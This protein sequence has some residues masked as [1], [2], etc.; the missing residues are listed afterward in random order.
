MAPVHQVIPTIFLPLITFNAPG[1]RVPFILPP[2]P[3]RPVAGSNERERSSRG[4]MQRS[5]ISPA[6]A[7]APGRYGSLLSNAAF[8]G[9]TISSAMRWTIPSGYG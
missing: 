5:A 4:A 7:P 1:V 8:K 3:T 9:S 6:P 2:S